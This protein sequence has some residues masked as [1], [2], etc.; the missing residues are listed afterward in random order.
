MTKKF[1][2][3]DNP[4][5]LFTILVGLIFSVLIIYMDLFSVNILNFDYMAE[6][7]F[8]AGAGFI[9]F[10]IC[11]LFNPV[12]RLCTKNRFFLTGKS[13]LVVWVMLIVSLSVCEVG[14][15]SQFIPT[16]AGLCYFG[17]EQNKWLELI[18]P[19]IKK[20]L[21][22]TDQSV[23]KGF[24][25]GGAGVPWGI[26]LKTFAPW[27]IFLIFFYFTSLCIV[28]I[29]QKQW[30]KN[31]NLQFPINEVPLSMVSSEEGG[32]LPS[33]F[34]NKLFWLGF[35]ISFSISSFNGLHKLS[36]AFPGLAPFFIPAF[37]RTVSIYL[38]FSFPVIG[39]TYF[40]NS[41]LSFSLWFFALFFYILQGS[42][43]LLGVF[44]SEN[45][46]V[47]SYNAA[48][49][50][51]FSHFSF[52][53]LLCYVFYAIWIS[54]RHLKNIFRSATGKEK[55]EE[56]PDNLLSY[57]VS[58][59]GLITGFCCMWVWLT[60]SGINFWIS[61]L[62]V[63]LVF[64][65]LIGLTKIVAQAGVF[66]LKSPSIASSQIV[67][68]F[69]SKNID[70][71][72]LSNMGLS[73]AYHS[74]VR[75]F[76]LSSSFHS[77]KL[78]EKLNNNIRPLF[79][80]II[81]SLLVGIFTSFFILLKM[82]Y[83]YGGLNLSPWY[84]NSVPRF[85]WQWIGS[86]IL[87]P[88][89]PNILGIITKISG[90]ISMFVLLSIYSKFTWFPFHPLGLAVA[91]TYRVMHPVFSIFLGWL[92]KVMTMKLGGT[93]AYY[94]GKYVAIGLICGTCVASGV[95]FFIAL[96]TGIKNFNIF[97]T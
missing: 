67:S 42:F 69:G 71:N 83:K 54:R 26:W 78:G 56:E 95:W 8:P 18:K 12:L 61:F 46:G 85:P 81:L 89:K 79:W 50:P 14:L 2:D 66:T 21:I 96:L 91:S 75:T 43:N 40:V 65:I 38:L 80:I 72:T 4:F 45:L 86:H 6:D 68:V 22:I 93:K 16:I 51:F 58:F 53:A 3:K 63:I 90:F 60:F 23:L 59:W 36:P 52:G 57:R 64:I 62:F 30:I 37:R 25:E 1:F 15:M 84:F 32:V 29:F 87:Y 47:G 35:L 77:V 34:K 27:L 49:G 73:Y 88:E 28:S 39:F 94:N 10:V 5:N 76:P 82:A 97:L 13:L 70:L 55:L 20:Y 9:F 7:H 41:K 44:F 92:F 74:D 33:L 11:I 48:G 17:D 31:E 24:F 19:N